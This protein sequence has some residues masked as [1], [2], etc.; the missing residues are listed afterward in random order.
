MSVPRILIL[1]ALG[2]AIGDQALAASNV[3]VVR[4]PSLLSFGEVSQLVGVSYS[5]A[6][7]ARKHSSTSSSLLAENYRLGTIATVVD[8]EIATIELQLG[9]SYQQSFADKTTTYLNGQY[10]IMTSAFS[11]SSHPATLVSTRSTSVIDNGFT[12]AYTLTRDTEQ[13][14]ASLLHDVLPLRIAYSHG[15]SGSS[16]LAQNFSSS[17]DSFSMNATHSYKEISNSLVSLD[18]SADSSS[19][20]HSSAYSLLFNN[21]LTFDEKRRYVLSSKVQRQDNKSALVPQRSLALS[22]ALSCRFGPALLGSF[23]YDYSE[24][25]TVDFQQTPQNVLVNTYSASLSHR[26]FAS[27][28]TGV[29]GTYSKSESYGGTSSSY[30]GNLNLNY[31]KQLPGQNTLAIS[32]AFSRK[33]TEQSQPNSVI[34]A[35]NERQTA[36]DQGTFIVPDLQGRL[37]SVP[38]VRSLLSD[39]PTIPDTTYVENLDYAVDLVQGRIVILVG[40]AIARGTV[41]RISYTVDV[42]P[43]VKFQSDTFNSGFVLTMLSGRYTLAGDMSK[44]D[45]TLLAG[46]D[47]SQGLSHTTNYNLRATARYPKSS[48]GLEY[49]YSKS[50]SQEFSKLGGQ[51]S[52]NTQFSRTDNFA[53]N[54]RNDLTIYPAR[55]GGSGYT[56]NTLTTS[57]NYSWL[58]YDV[59]RSSVMVG[60]NDSR[61]RFGSGQTASAKLS[62]NADFRRLSVALTA[63]TMYRISG[64]T[65]NRD[66]NIALSVSRSF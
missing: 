58:L 30:G 28:S 21:D 48:L 27:L 29:A 35:A 34:S 25:S 2:L 59:L 31:S 50:T 15:S 55:D 3:E 65:A 14:S 5:F 24:S 23:S 39:N 66:S 37:V 49:A 52:Y 32:S 44:L 40:G 54:A 45:E 4:Q 11:T 9:I 53:F 17:G 51:Y 26:L 46:R 1:A 43:S 19:G 18:Y 20:Q 63:L 56:E 8:P 41:L 36:G 12:P 7:H 10:N 16:G 22:E 42:N 33:I 47:Q 61:S 38:S 57:A 62:L 60:I 64:S 6:E 13:L